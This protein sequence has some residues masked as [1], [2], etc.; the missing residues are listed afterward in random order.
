MEVASER[1]DIA[2]GFVAAGACGFLNSFSEDDLREFRWI[3]QSMGEAFSLYAPGSRLRDATKVT[4]VDVTSFKARPQALFIVIPDRYLMAASPF[5]S[6]VLDYIVETAAHAKGPHRV[7]IL[8]EEFA[9]LPYN[10]NVVKWLRTYRALGIRFISVVQDGS[11]CSKFKK[12][13]AH[14]PFEENSV[15]LYFGISDPDHLQHLERRAGK[16][17]VLIE[18]ASTSLGIK[19]PGKNKGGTE[20]LT[21]VLPVSEIAKIGMGQALLDIPGQPI[22]ILGRKPWWE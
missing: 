22:F 17:A 3:I 7:A 5:V 10:E 21:P 20:Q 18:T 16:R 13:G 4:N 6:A 9:A 2:G 1:T 19:V 15:K 14:R 8:A 12:F 11:Y